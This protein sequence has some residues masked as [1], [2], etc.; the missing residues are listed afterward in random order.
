M[1]KFRIYRAALALSSIA[2]LVVV[3]GAGHKFS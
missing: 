1:L 2:A 3:S